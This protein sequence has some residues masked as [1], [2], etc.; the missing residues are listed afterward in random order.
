MT[1]NLSVEE[2]KAALK[3]ALKEWL[4]EKFAVFGKWSMGTIGAAAVF[5]LGYFILSTNGWHRLGN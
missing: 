3:E 2:T 5:A 1:D 4:D